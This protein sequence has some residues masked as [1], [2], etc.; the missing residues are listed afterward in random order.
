VLFCHTPDS[1]CVRV[2][3]KALRT[4]KATGETRVLL[5]NTLDQTW[6]MT[7]DEIIAEPDYVTGGPWGPFWGVPFRAEDEEPIYNLKQLFGSTNPQ[8]RTF[9][10]RLSEDDELT[11]T[12]HDV[13]L[14]G[15]SPL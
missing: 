14:N 15:G 1:V 5:R 3:E 4:Y 13:S 10:D 2:S 11:I 12:K 6:M 7:P 8:L 9:Q